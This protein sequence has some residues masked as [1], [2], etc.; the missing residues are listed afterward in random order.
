MNPCCNHCNRS[1]FI[2][3]RLKN[4]KGTC[5]LKFHKP[6]YYFLFALL[7][8]LSGY[9]ILAAEEKQ[10]ESISRNILFV[11]SYNAS[12]YWTNKVMAGFRD[13]FQRDNLPAAIN[14]L[15]LGVANRSGLVPRKRELELL[16]EQLAYS[17]DLIVTLD[18]PVADLFLD[19][20]VPMPRNTP[21]LI[22]GYD[23]PKL[24]SGK[25]RRRNITGMAMPHSSL[26][27]LELGLKLLPKTKKAVFLIGGTSDGINIQQRLLAAK[28]RFPGIELE[29]I[30]GND[31][32]TAEMLQRLAGLSPEDSFLVFHHWISGKDKLWKRQINIFKEV[33]QQYHGPIFASFGEIFQEGALGGIITDPIQFGTEGAKIAKRILA[34]TKPESIPVRHCR[35]TAKLNYRQLTLQGIPPDRLPENAVLEQEPETFWQRHYDIVLWSVFSILLLILSGLGWLYFYLKHIRRLRVIFK[36]M[37]IHAVAVDSAGK[38]R[39]FQAE[40]PENHRQATTWDDLPEEVKR[41]LKGPVENVLESGCPQELEY[42]YLGCRRRAEIIKLPKSVFGVETVLWTSSNINELHA[43]SERFRLTLQSIGDAVIV[44]DAEEAVTLLNPPA[45]ALTGFTQEEARGKKLTEIFNIISYIDGR[46]VPS[47][48]AQA[49]SLGRVVELAN[50][51]DLIAKDGSRRHIADSASPIRDGE[52]RITGGVLI[53]RDVTGEY[54]NRDQMRLQSAILKSIGKIA[55]FSYFRCDFQ[56]AP[57]Y[58]VNENFWPRRNGIPVP[59]GEWVSPECHAELRA[60]WKRFFSGKE[61]ELYAAYTAGNPK[62]FYEIRAT[63]SAN[64]VTGKDEF[65]GLILDVTHIREEEQRHRN[66]LQLLTSIMDHLQGYIF[67]KNADDGFRYLMANRKFCEISGMRPEDI[68]GKTDA[69]IFAHSPEAMRRYRKDD[70]ALLAAGGTC[71]VLE[72]VPFAN[73]NEVVIQTVKSLL[74][75][76]DGM[77]FIIGLSIDVTRQNKLE[78]ERR[79]LLEDLKLYT[80]QERL[81]NSILEKVTLQTDDDEAL[82]EI[83]RSIIVHLGAMTSYIFHTDLESGLDIP[84]AEYWPDAHQKTKIPDLPVD[85]ASPWFRQVS[86]H[87]IFEVPETGTEEAKRIQGQWAQYMPAFGVGAIY[88]VGVWVDKKFWGHMGFSYPKPRGRLTPQERFLLNSAA[89]MV[90]IILE[91]RKNRVELNRSENEKLLILDTMNI[92]IMLF[93]PEMQLIRCNNAA[94]KITGMAE[95]EVYRIGC[96]KAFCG[97]KCRSADCPVARVHDD[98]KEHVSELS[99]KGREYQI[100]AYPII[101]DNKLVYIMKTMIDVTE[102]NTIQQKLTAALEQAQAASKAKSYFLATMSHEI[103]TPLNAVIGF[104]ELLKGGGLSPEEQTEFLDSINFAGNSLLRLI[105]DVLDLSKLEAEQTVL[106]AHPTDLAVLLHEIQA[107][108]QYKIQEKNLSF[109]LNCPAGLPMLK[110]DNLRLRQILLNLIGNAVK[111]TA[112]GGITLIAG[113]RQ[114]GGGKGTLSIQVQDTGIGIPEEAQLKI[115]E[116]FVQSDT[117]RDTH[118][119]GGTGLGLAIC[120][121]LAERMNGKITLESEVGKGSCFTLTL[122][123]IE[124]LEPDTGRKPEMIAEPAAAP[125]NFRV[126]LVDDV[127]LNLKVLA[128]MLRK[129]ETEPLTA[130]SGEEALELLKREQVDL[131]LT[132]M[133]MPSMN[134]AE[135]AAA[136]RN[137]SDYDRIPVIAVTADAEAGSNFS[138]EHLSGLLLKPVTLEKLDALLN[139]FQNGKQEHPVSRG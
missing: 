105:N 81:L 56:G 55:N 114:E 61:E 122:A 62:R 125:R 109:R 71:E 79:D 28:K 3:S 30:S 112:Q 139:R 90:E 60:A 34:G 44:T 19:G 129:L 75:R 104:S 33:K 7:F 5:S 68:I 73:G 77:R 100:R 118:I 16:R 41:T 103:R 53:F 49:L 89:H 23:G 69:E 87:E 42:T 96:Q 21:L 80:E 43:M 39:F 92:P 101:I 123:E 76:S 97:E 85:S 27:S 51:T 128:A 91:R 108:F 20:Q 127:P 113:F 130:D 45:A 37:P 12:Q 35:G 134:G 119:Y 111:F 84:I 135:L 54:E 67:V 99:I 8:L 22:L 132:D 63:K 124:L 1:H 29:I 48:L 38:I 2:N 70:E 106:T 78:K 88:G 46:K 31:C 93:N 32:S 13:Y 83:L 115:F 138:Q 120:R 102:F 86:S 72:T 47:P 10:P 133:W 14:V 117:A 59:A 74:T 11:T 15:E 131:I 98:L 24:D 4:T 65:F 25:K 64:P 116:P 40:L 57:L 17:Y 121:R 36:A 6:F 52:N 66:D 137:V 58:H 82:Q 126:L 110:L 94:L 95:K 50:H 107:I 26:D 18:N 136:I 9:S